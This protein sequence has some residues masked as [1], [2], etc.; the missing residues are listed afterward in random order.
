MKILDFILGVICVTGCT[1]VFMTMSLIMYMMTLWYTLYLCIRRK[2][3]FKTEIN[4][5]NKT[6]ITN[7]ENYFHNYL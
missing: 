7:M 1:V 6:F 2:G 3:K 4:R 5:L